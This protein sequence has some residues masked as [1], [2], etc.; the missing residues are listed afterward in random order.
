MFFYEKNHVQLKYFKYLFKGSSPAR[1]PSLLESNVS[2]PCVFSGHL[3]T[4]LSYG[5]P[6]A[7][8]TW[9]MCFWAQ[10]DFSSPNVK[11]LP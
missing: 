11:L 10:S 8:R 6:R 1:L 2:G 9:L 7:P 3:R 4:G 5:P